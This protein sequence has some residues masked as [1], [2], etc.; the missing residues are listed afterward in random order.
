MAGAEDVL[1]SPACFPEWKQQEVTWFHVTMHEVVL[2]R[3]LASACHLFY[4][5]SD[6]DFSSVCSGLVKPQ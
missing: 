1:D 3:E 6:D 2:A 4:L 5:E